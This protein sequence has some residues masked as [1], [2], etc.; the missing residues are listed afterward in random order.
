M[1]KIANKNLISFFIMPIH[2]AVWV[3]QYSYYETKDTILF[4]LQVDI[5]MYLYTYNSI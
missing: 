5:I 4:N 2:L 1:G 3:L